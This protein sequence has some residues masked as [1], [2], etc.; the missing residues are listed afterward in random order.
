MWPP[1]VKDPLEILAELPKFLSSASGSESASVG[2]SGPFGYSNHHNHPVGLVLVLLPLGRWGNKYMVREVQWPSSISELI[3]GRTRVQNHLTRFHSPHFSKTT[4]RTIQVFWLP[5]KPPISPSKGIS[6][7][8]NNKVGAG[9]GVRS[10]SGSGDYGPG[11]VPYHTPWRSWA[12]FLL[13]HS[14]HVYWA[15]TVPFWTLGYRCECPCLVEVCIFE[16]TRQ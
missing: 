13:I 11:L 16:G 12:R 15:P 10:D 9:T 3:S 8:P 7:F 6:L 4:K 2:K 14:V 5:E 1:Q